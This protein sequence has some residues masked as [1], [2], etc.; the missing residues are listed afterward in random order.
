VQSPFQLVQ[1]FLGSDR[2]NRAGT[3]DHRRAMRAQKIVILRR[4]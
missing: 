1:E 4:E 2:D 3:E